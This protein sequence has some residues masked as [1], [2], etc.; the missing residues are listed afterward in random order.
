MLKC[1]RLGYTNNMT[2]NI[3][4]ETKNVI[5]IFALATGFTLGVFAVLKMYDALLLVLIAF[6]IALALNPAVGF[7][8]RAIPGKRRGPAIAIVVVAVFALLT[9]L[10]ASIVPPIFRET[11]G[12]VDTLPETINN[13]FYRNERVQGYIEQYQLQDEIDSAIET[14][15]N[16]LSDAGK[17]VVSSAGTVGSSFL[18]SLTVLVMAVLMLTGG[19]QLLQRLANAF[20][21]DQKLRQRHEQIA[22][23]MYRSVTGYVV[24]QVSVALIASLFALGALVLLGVP[25]PLPLASIVFVLGLIP[26][27]GNM[28]AAILVVLSTFVLKDVTAGLI[29]LAFFVVYQQLENITLQPIVQGKTTNLP[30]LVIFVSVI[31]G[32]ALIGPIGGLLAIPAVGCAK[33]LLQDY[34]AHRDDFTPEDSPKTVL[35]KVKRKVTNKL[36]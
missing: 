21:R 7:L 29:L 28:L 1:L 35:E 6:F 17:D 13:S 24:G 31:L 18:T 10:L 22:Q 30:P 2:L 27:I 8:S 34:L 4:V 19:P 36:A 3:N 11:S 26:L 14:G 9:F 23:K 16:R 12:F 15:K 5:K 33:V 20:Y 32:V 25:Y